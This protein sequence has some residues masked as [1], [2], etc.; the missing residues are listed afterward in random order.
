MGTRKESREGPGLEEI[1]GNQCRFKEGSGKLK[2]NG[3]VILL[4]G[5]RLYRNVV[6]GFHVR[7]K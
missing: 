1:V 6:A 3:G 4:H 2:E 5:K 7:K